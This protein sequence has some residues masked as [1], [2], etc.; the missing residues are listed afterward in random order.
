MTMTETLSGKLREPL[1]FAVI[2]VCATGVHFAILSL[3]V[4]VLGLLPTLANAL[5]FFCAV[6]A[7]YLG[8]SRWVFR[9]APALQERQQALWRVSRF[10]VSVLAGFLGNITI[11]HVAT[12]IW[13]IDYR[14][15]FV[16]C[17]LIVP[18]LTFL[19]NKF[20]VFEAR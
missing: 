7:T 14:I 9:T 1:R 20:W 6:W 5:A 15:A 11:M 10:G 4:E 16:I 8:Q 12:Q 19:L 18:V 17:T 2:G 3:G 13:Q